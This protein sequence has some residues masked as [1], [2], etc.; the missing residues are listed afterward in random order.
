[1]GPKTNLPGSLSNLFKDV[2]AKEYTSVPDERSQNLWIS[3]QEPLMTGNAFEYRIRPL[4]PSE[5]ALVLM[6][7]GKLVPYDS[8]E[9]SFFVS[10]S[11]YV[12]VLLMLTVRTC[13]PSVSTA[14]SRIAS[15][16]PP[17]TASSM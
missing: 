17:I 6:P 10:R 12:T 14:I 11:Q 4:A 16:F 5:T 13:L 1:M 15:P 3:D 7:P 8:V 9:I 2:S